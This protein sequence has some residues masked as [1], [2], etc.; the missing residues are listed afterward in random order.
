M[1]NTSQPGYLNALIRRVDELLSEAV[2]IR[3][4]I[5]RRGRENPFWPDRRQARV[6][7]FPERRAT[8]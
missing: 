5:M 7:V 4:E 6:P 8:G 3:E 1:A 2:R